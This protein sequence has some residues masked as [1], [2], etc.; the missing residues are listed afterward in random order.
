MF[1]VLKV[2]KASV[3]ASESLISLTKYWKVCSGIEIALPWDAQVVF[4][5]LMTLA[6]SFI[7]LD[8]IKLVL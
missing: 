5:A 3:Q 4:W 8:F 1:N 6:S 7:E 2:T